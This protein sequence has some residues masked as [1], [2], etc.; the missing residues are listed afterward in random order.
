MSYI[1]ALPRELRDL[2]NEFA[3]SA[4]RKDLIKIY[5][6]YIFDR[7]NDSKEI[8]KFLTDDIAMVNFV[9]LYIKIVGCRIFPF[10]PNLKS[11]I[12]LNHILKMVSSEKFLTRFEHDNKYL[13]EI[14]SILAK[15]NVFI[16]K[17]YI[18][19]GGKLVL[20]SEFKF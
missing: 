4:F 8:N 2:L 7:R 9:E 15:Y 12:T 3:Y 16:C 14:N 18:N 13:S 5:F 19:K 1:D 17:K 6:Y 20:A 11:V 10:V